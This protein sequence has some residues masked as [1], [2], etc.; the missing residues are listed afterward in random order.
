MAPEPSLKD[1]AIEIVQI[2]VKEDNA[3]NYPQA[4]DLYVQAVRYVPI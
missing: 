1:K 3:G 4:L 2:A